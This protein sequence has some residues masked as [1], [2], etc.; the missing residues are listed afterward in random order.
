MH[1]ATSDETPTVIGDRTYWMVNSHVGHDCQV[2]NDSVFANGVLLGGS[3]R[4]GNGVIMGGNTAVHQFCRVGRGALLSGVLGLSKDLP[5]FFMLTG[6]DLAGSIN[7]VGMRRAKMPSDQIDDVKWVYKTLFRREL[8]F[9]RAVD[10]I[11]SR[12]DREIVAEYLAFFEASERGIVRG[13]ADPRRGMF[14]A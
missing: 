8:S 9:K 13:K 2:G 12:A 6:G 10:E 5:P 4:V 14:T 3:V 7:L 11:R 1:R